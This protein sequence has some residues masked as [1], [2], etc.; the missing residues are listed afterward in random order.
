MRG[1]E[2]GRLYEQ[3]NKKPYNPSKVSQAVNKL[4][5]DSSVNNH[6]GIFEFILGGEKDTKLLEIR[7]FDDVTK[8][9][10][11]EKQ[12]ASSKKSGKSNCLLCAVGHD[13]NSKKIWKEDEMDADHVAAWSKGGATDITN[14]QL[15]CI[16]HNRAKGNR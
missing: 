15:L 2:W 8:H 9:S 4:Y 13:A 6:K 3:Y 11:Y 7:I 16:P 12:T 10:T 5:S 14:C 1:L